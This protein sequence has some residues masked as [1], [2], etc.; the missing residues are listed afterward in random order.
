MVFRLSVSTFVI[1]WA[2]CSNYAMQV[3]DLVSSA[4]KPFDEF[5]WQAAAI[6]IKIAVSLFI[7]EK[8]YEAILVYFNLRGA[9]IS[10]DT[11]EI[12]HRL[13]QIASN[14]A[15]EKVPPPV[16]LHFANEGIFFEN[17]DKVIRHSIGKVDISFLQ[18]STECTIE[19]S[20]LKLE[21]AIIRQNGTIKAEIGWR[22]STIV[23]TTES[24]ETEYDHGSFIFEIS[25]ALRRLKAM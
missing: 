2:V 10:L 19:Y 13:E 21:S 15:L 8:L 7:M 11:K 14:M 17:A 22:G 16:N 4:T 9:L 23:V 24:E 3:F 25:T 6:S 18:S 12:C 20:E 1:W 5:L